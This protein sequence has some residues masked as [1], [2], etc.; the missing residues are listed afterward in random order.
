MD[1]VKETAD[2]IV[3]VNQYKKGQLEDFEY[4][5]SVCAYF[6]KIKSEQ[7]TE[8]DYKFLRFIAT[9]SGIPHFYNI[10]KQFN[11][12]PDIDNF[13]LKELVISKVPPDG[14]ASKLLSK[15]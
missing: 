9:S 6:D 1:R 15:N 14:N 4:I 3:E 11:H 7:L 12:N 5:K 2:L 13:D 8:N 10:L